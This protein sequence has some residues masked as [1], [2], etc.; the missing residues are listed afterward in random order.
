MWSSATGA[1][2]LFPPVPSIDSANIAT[3]EEVLLPYV[4]VLVLEMQD[5]ILMDMMP[6]IEVRLI[7]MMVK[8]DVAWKTV[9]TLKATRQMSRLPIL[10]RLPRRYLRRW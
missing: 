1:K 9:A 7:K 4:P 5:D 3:V 6:F 2:S 8:N 10:Y